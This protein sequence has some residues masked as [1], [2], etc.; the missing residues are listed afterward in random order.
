MH[1]YIYTECIL[2]MVEMMRRTSLQQYDKMQGNRRRQW[3]ALNQ[4]IFT[5]S[6]VWCNDGYLSVGVCK[7]MY[8]NKGNTWGSILCS[9]IC[10][11]ISEID[12]RSACFIAEIDMK[13]QLLCY[14]GMDNKCKQL[15]Y[16]VL[17]GVYKI[18]TIC[19]NMQCFCRHFA[20]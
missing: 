6:P 11:V 17:S 10:R 20:I 4:Y 15:Y 19:P 2:T 3:D 1:I 12:T 18:S 5:H 14:T 8:V 9:M 16:I 7:L 13:L